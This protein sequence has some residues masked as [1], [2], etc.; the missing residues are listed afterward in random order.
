MA[1]WI[2]LLIGFV[3][4]GLE[5]VSTTLH[6]GFFAAGAF[7]VALLLLFGWDGPLW[8][9]LLLSTAISI[10]TFLVFRPMVVRRL[11]LHQTPPV[12][13]LVGEEA[14]AIEEIAAQGRGRAELRGSTWSAFNVGNTPLGPGQRCRVERVE[15]LLLHVSA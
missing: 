6:V 1:W 14:V 9:Q 4:L 12:D 7:A 11:R 13:Q 15:G 10:V 8:Q 5:L 2:W 3:I